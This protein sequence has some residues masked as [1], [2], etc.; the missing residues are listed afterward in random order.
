M[1]AKLSLKTLLF[2]LPILLLLFFAA[3]KNDDLEMVKENENIRAGADFIK[4][5]YQLSL[6]SAA[7]E[8]A[9]MYDQ[10]N[11]AG[12]FTFLAP[13]DAAFNAMGILRASDFDKMN[14]DSLKSLVQRHVLNRRV[15][16]QDIPVNGVDV[17]Y[18]TLAGTQ[19]YASLASNFRGD[20]TLVINNLFYDGAFVERKDVQLTNGSLQLLN[21]VMKYD[22]GTVQDWLKKRPEYSIFVAGLKKFGLWDKLATP[23]PFTVFAPT[24]AAL[25]TGGITAAVMDA[26]VPSAYNGNR[27]FGGY[28][29]EG[30][31]FFISD[32]QVFS[33]F[34]SETA[35]LKELENDTWCT[36]LSVTQANDQSLRYALRLKKAR[37]GFSYTTSSGGNTSMVT[38]D[39]LTDNG[40][41]HSSTGV[42]AKLADARK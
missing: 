33:A 17:R 34:G 14:R 36:Q 40:V 38:V 9:G 35:Y 16:L 5:N 41:V 37:T 30:K 7:I 8:K 6:F 4:N 32:V 13:S 1:S 11:G 28:I 31:H 3:C 12:P 18:A 42:I 23:G 10:L 2:H 24:N 21:K 22:S 25:T 26:L 29:L 19:V 27:L 15:I 39:Y 20:P